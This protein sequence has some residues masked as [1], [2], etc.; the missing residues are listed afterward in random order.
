MLNININEDDAIE[1]LINRLKGWTDDETTIK[2]YED[3]Y[4]SYIMGGCF[5][6]L[7]FDV[8]GIVD[9]DYIN[10]CDVISKDDERFNNI[11]KVYNAQGLG[12]CSCEDCDG[13]FIEAVDNEEKPEAFLIRW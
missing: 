11:L 4:T 12:D 1:L 13:D 10:Y 9:N 7:D 2:L 3:M 6:G 5:Y 8:S